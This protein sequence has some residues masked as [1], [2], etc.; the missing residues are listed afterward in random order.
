VEAIEAIVGE[1]RKG[2]GAIEAVV[3]GREKGEQEQYDN[4]SRS[5]ES[6]PRRG[7][8]SELRREL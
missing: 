8:E 7:D 3:G 5:D 1:R 6:N 4:R 2:V